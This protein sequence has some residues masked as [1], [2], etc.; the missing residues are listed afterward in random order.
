MTDCK[1]NYIHNYVDQNYDYIIS[2]TDN[3]NSAEYLIK[4]HDH[5]SK[6]LG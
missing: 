1:S 3:N 5:V 4:F 2:L 6:V